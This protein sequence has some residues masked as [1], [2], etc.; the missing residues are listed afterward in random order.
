MLKGGSRKDKGTGPLSLSDLLDRIITEVMRMPR[1]AREKS[2]TG[3]LI[4]M[5]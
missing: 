1:Q 4:T 3:I 5:G 2:E